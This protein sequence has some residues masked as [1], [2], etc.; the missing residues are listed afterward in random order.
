MTPLILFIVGVKIA[1]MIS[2]V[3]I[4]YL[5]IQMKRHPSSEQEEELAKLTFLKSRFEFIFIILMS[6]LILI[7]FNPMKKTVITYKTQLLF[8]MYGIII[9]IT[10]NWNIFIK[11]SPLF[12]KIKS[13]L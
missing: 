3:L 11:E 9:L 7:T 8:F 13:I 4:L 5:H 6:I 10:A 1:F 2:A 12:R